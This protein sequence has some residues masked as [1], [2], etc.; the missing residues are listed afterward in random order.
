M[1]FERRHGSDLADLAD[2]LAERETI[3][4]GYRQ[5]RE[6]GNPPLEHP[7]RFMEIT[8]PDVYR[9]AGG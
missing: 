8:D 2:L 1:A 7:E 6:D 5:T 4:A 9:R 3:E